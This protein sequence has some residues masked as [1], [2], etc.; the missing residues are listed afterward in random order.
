[1]VIFGMFLVIGMTRGW[2]LIDALMVMW[3]LLMMIVFSMAPQTQINYL[4]RVV[5]DKDVDIQH[6]TAQLEDMV[7]KQIQINLSQTKI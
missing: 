5:V 3:M 6:A 4:N 1:M 7:R 2:S